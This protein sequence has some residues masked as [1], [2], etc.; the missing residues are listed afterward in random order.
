LALLVFVGLVTPALVSGLWEYFQLKQEANQDFHTSGKTLTTILAQGLG[1]PLWDYDTASVEALLQSAK[2]NPRVVS[3]RVDDPNGQLF[4]GVERPLRSG[5]LE[6]TF[7]HSVTHADQVIGQLLLV[8]DKSY[9]LQRVSSRLTAIW[10]LLAI[11]LFLSLL[12]I[13]IFLQSRFLLPLRTL[14][15]QSAA[16]A[17]QDLA[18]AFVWTGNDEL[19]R[20]GRSL[21]AT[22]QALVIY[23]ENLEGLI[24]ERT[25]ELEN[26]NAELEA[27]NYS[28][29]HDLRAPL[30]VID[31]YAGVLTEDFGPALVPQ[32]R[33]YLAKIQSSAARMSSL[34]DDLLRL[35]RVARSEL[36]PGTV[37]LAKL[38]ESIVEELREAEPTRNVEFSCSGPLTVFA[39]LGLM[40]IA[41]QNLLG[42]AWKYTS[43]TPQA[44]VSLK[45]SLE[46]AG[47]VYIVEDNGTGFD[48]S[49]VKNLFQPFVRLH[50]SSNFEGNGIGLAI[51]ERIVA[52]HGGRAWAQSE[53]GTGARFFFSLGEI[54]G[55]R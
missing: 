10:V 13:V 47:R 40:R 31:G 19:G 32:A 16:L 7:Q 14:E 39:D 51:V 52:R 25:K 26:A 37:D 29:S 36:H 49:S 3:I 18:Q 6:E 46:P 11:Q 21:E 41:L 17:N 20:L 34:M 30:R 38:A 22:R 5:G 54:N 27:F 48:M 2:T 43:R 44:R 55:L 4:A 53:A 12:L 50:E 35:S 1:E 9:D 42:N 8:M 33:Q 28:V 24:R 23:K 45:A 15:A